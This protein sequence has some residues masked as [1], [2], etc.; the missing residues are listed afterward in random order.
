MATYAR[1]DASEFAPNYAKYLDF[2]MEEEDILVHLKAQGIVIL[3]LLRTLDDEQTEYRY[4]PGKWSIKE[5]IGHLMDMERLFVFRAL[6]FA[7]GGEAPLPGVDED[8]WAA[9]SNAGRR[10]LAALWREHHV[11]RTDHL[12]VLRS[13][14]EEAIDRRGVADGKTMSVRAIPWIITGHEYHHLQ[15]LRERYGLTW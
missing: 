9:V 8:G 6:W 5:L 4:A 1:P 13:L 2:P 12:Y 11:S 7:R 15:I 3:T 14:D 10:P